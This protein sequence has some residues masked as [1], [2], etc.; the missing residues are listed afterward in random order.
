MHKFFQFCI[1]EIIKKKNYINFYIKKWKVLHVAR[2]FMHKL[3]L[4][5]ERIGYEWLQGGNFLV[6]GYLACL[7]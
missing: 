2:V 7:G 6:H 3:N 4:N 5:F 1:Q